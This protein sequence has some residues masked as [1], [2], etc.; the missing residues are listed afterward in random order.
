MEHVASGV[1][2]FPDAGSILPESSLQAR[3]VARMGTLAGHWPRCAWQARVPAIFESAAVRAFA[4]PADAEM[5]V[6][7][8]LLWCKA[9]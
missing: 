5:L 3:R 8:E 9:V 6:C 4:A 2:S 7:L 1:P